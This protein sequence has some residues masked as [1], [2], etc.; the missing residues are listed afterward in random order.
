MKLTM[1]GTGHAV[2]TK[3]YNTCFVLSENDNYLLVDGGGGNTLLNQL[4]KAHI[5]WRQI[6]EIFVTH[7]HIDHLL[8]IIWMIRLMTSEMMMGKMRDDVFIY[9]H[10]EVIAI[11]ESMSEQLLMPKQ[12]N[13]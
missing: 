2:V 13:G 10:N 1:L 5:D 12:K 6:K 4:E 7:Q 11:L 3:C 8:G 9:A